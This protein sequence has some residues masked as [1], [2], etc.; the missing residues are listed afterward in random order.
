MEKVVDHNKVDHAGTQTLE[1]IF[2]RDKPS[3]KL[4]KDSGGGDKVSMSAES[5]G[6]GNCCG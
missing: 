2:T 6:T 5:D 1:N 4:S 3:R